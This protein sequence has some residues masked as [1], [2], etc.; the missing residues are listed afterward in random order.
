M[1]P[2]MNYLGQLRK[3]K[4]GLVGWGIILTFVFIAIFA[5]LISPYNP[6]AISGAYY[7]H[8]SML[9]LF[10]TNQEGQDL[11]S[12]NM[13]GT[14]IPLIVG[15]TAALVAVVLGLLVGLFSGYFGGVPDEILMRITDFF[16][17]VPAIVLMIV[18]SAL[19]GG[20]LTNVI[21]IIGGLS[22]PMTARVVRSMVLS[23]KEWPFVE[24]AKSSNGSSLYIMFK[25]IL[26]NVMPVVFANAA[27]SVAN[28]IFTQAALVFI[29]VG[30]VTDLS[31]GNIMHFAYINGTIT[32][33]I[34]WYMIPPGIFIVLLTVGFIFLS[35]SF[36]T[37]F[38][39][40]TRRI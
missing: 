33:G 15:T 5:P 16:L 2:L 7:Q 12:Q 10:G 29:G 37:I 1:N 25:H 27:L 14:R 34:W 23:I 28:A 36:E 8:P 18:I 24:V 9:H 31:W 30:D 39:P 35:T 26:P 40:R 38:N 6:N 17:V 32:T 22:W 21:L 4:I 20:T 3:S 11:F 13:Y 19:I